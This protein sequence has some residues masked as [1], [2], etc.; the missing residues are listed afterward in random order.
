M[1]SNLASLSVLQG[2]N[3]ILPLLVFPY[4]V[5]VLGVSQYGLI[6]FAQALLNYFAVFTDYGFTLSATRAVS[7]S[8]ND[9]RKLASVFRAVITTKL[10]LIFISLVVTVLIVLAFESVRAE[11]PLYLLSFTIVLGHALTPTWFFQG[12]EKM[13]FITYSSLVGKLVSTLLIFTLIDSEADYIW[14]NVCLGV[15]N[16]IAGVLGLFFI[17][18]YFGISF[19]PASFR[20]IRQELRSGWAIFISSFAISISISSNLFILGLFASSTVVGFYSIAEK[21]FLILRTVAQLLYQVVYPQVCLL[22]GE[23]FRALA[24]FL[25]KITKLVLVLFVPAGLIL[26]VF[27]DY[28]IY[29]V[30]GQ[31]VAES[32]LYLRILCF[33]PLFAALDIPA[34]QTMLAY[35]LNKSY[36]AISAAGAAVNI[37][38]NFTLTPFLL[39]TGT[40]I[41]SLVTEVF[42]ALALYCYLY[43]RYPHYIFWKREAHLTIKE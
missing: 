22:A 29:L 6:S 41:A 17:Y 30:A 26:F 18:R 42:I 5:R 2:A 21:L 16:L 33:A 34:C 32:A 15:A 12:V 8:R 1:L 7:V 20:S 9:P 27:A 31:F 19:H 25:V 39:G 38:L 4:L 43:H 3:L 37:L 10:L 40:A 23:S 11:A 13:Q 35:H 24:A 36:A 14:V 28:I